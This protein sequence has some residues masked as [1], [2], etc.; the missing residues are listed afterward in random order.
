MKPEDW[1]RI[2]NI[3]QATLDQSPNERNAF[4]RQAC[5]SDEELREEV[6]SLVKAYETSEGFL[7]EDLSSIA[8]EV[9]AANDTGSATIGER[10]GVYE[11]L[12]NLGS[13]GMG[14]VYLARDTKLGRKI[15]LK[16]LPAEFST[17]EKRLRRFEQEARLASNLNH[18]NICT[19]HEIGET[20]DGRRFIVMEYVDG[21]TLREHTKDR[22]VPSSEALDLA[23]QI[24]SALS[25]AHE[26]GII[27]R[28]IKPE[29]I[30]I[31]RDG[32][33]KVL[34]FGLA[35]LTEGIMAE[36]SAL[37][38]APQF[39]VTA[40][41]LVMGT[42]CYMS[43]EQARGQLVDGRTDIFSAGVILYQM[44][45]GKLPFTGETMS[46]CL[47]AVLTADP[48]PLAVAG[49][50]PSALQAVVDRAL[51]K[52]PADR[53]R[54]A[55]E[56]LTELKTIR[57]QFELGSPG[58]ARSAMHP[59]ARVWTRFPNFLGRRVLV[60]AGVGLLGV[61]AV[62][63]WFTRRNAT[64]RPDSIAVLPFDNKIG[65]PNS[66]YLS[67]GITESIINNL[68]QLPQLRVIP[69]SSVYRLKAPDSDPIE[70]GKKLGVHAIL[71]GRVTRRNDALSVSSEL[72]D[73]QQ[74]KQLW[75]RQYT[76]VMSDALSL[77][78][79]ISQDIVQQLKLELTVDQ[80]RRLAE[81]HTGDPQAYEVYL[82]G[83][84][85][86]NKRGRD[87]LMKA[88]PLFEQAIARDPQYPLAYVGMAR[89]LALLASNE[90][91]GYPPRETYARARAA[92]ERA[93]QLDPQLAEAY[94]SLGFIDTFDV[95]IQGKRAENEFK[96]A[97][98]INPNEPAAHHWYSVELARLGRLKERL[99]EAKR[100]RDLDAFSPVINAN[101]TS[102]LLDAG[103]LDAAL[104]QG[105][106]TLELEPNFF[107][108]VGFLGKC[109][110][111]Q[112][113]YS[114][115][116]PL[117]EKA[118]E[119]S[120]REP[121]PTTDLG[122]AYAESGRKAD[123]YKIAKELEA[124]LPERGAD[125]GQVAEVYAALGDK[126]RALRF[127][128]QGV[129]E[130]LLVIGDIEHEGPFRSMKDDPRYQKILERLRAAAKQ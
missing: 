51:E 97:I 113:R 81:N 108:A 17:D 24:A 43:P 90:T 119:M 9:L 110:L 76:R 38:S 73:V 45:S 86:L 55:N 29:N 4:L 11:I 27:H 121:E 116:I 47:A 127:L 71:T 40:P 52:N 31:R 2:E 59:T 72:V 122:I 118:T 16:I 128:E 107:G 35:K 79:A 106:K 20:N 78:A 12:G 67:D 104:E 18:P 56:L 25:A 7:E 111:M 64:A 98:D 66:D 49:E 65:Q 36:G 6:V 44:V 34:D 84:Y 109:Y 129:E 120:G 69:R 83:R 48:P 80:Q 57:R 58:G 41:G 10:L 125:P 103:E 30:M 22:R 61:I 23:T 99:V 1:P 91:P 53:F 5:G 75:G 115:A 100:A 70:V 88:Q 13:G 39:S 102:A 62:S 46:D 112:R 77:Q 3:L 126:D 105:K 123:A 92:A 42:V 32:Y 74:N 28:D 19:I 130:H 14:E 93:V 21:V 15:A 117:L 94:A 63:A 68:S 89:T 114:E 54:S 50:F 101:L 26:I 8:A 82:K 124:R 85:F 37:A 87:N 60:F 96:H 95:P 33:V